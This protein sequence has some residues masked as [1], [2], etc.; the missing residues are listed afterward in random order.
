MTD[1]DKIGSQRDS[2]STHCRISAKERKGRTQE[3]FITTIITCGV[4]D[5]PTAFI[6][7]KKIS[8]VIHRVIQNALGAESAALATALGRQLYRRLLSEK[9]LHGK[10]NEALIGHH[11]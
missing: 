8:T 11:D 7:V 9:V 10:P 5:A 4:E 1:L 6:M 3:G 2:V